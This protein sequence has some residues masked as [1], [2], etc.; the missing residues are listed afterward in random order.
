MTSDI[1][2]AN[3]IPCPYCRLPMRPILSGWPDLGSECD[4]C[5]TL[6]Y[7]AAGD[8]LRGEDSVKRPTTESNAAGQRPSRRPDRRLVPRGGRRD[9]DIPGR[10]PP[11][12][13]ADQ[14]EAARA[15]SVGYLNWFGF[16]VTEAASQDQAAAVI[17][18]VRPHAVLADVDL[19]AGL[20]PAVRSSVP[21][22]VTAAQAVVPPSL[23]PMALLSKPVEL[24]VMLEELRRV[25]RARVGSGFG[26]R[27]Q[28]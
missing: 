25:L 2:P 21:L 24:P 1:D 20:S 26:P 4:V 3:P 28:P 22:I 14:D 5:G 13:V 19:A 7:T 11:V 18:S 16:E 9:S 6:S 15:P 12:L 17:E 8:D 23:S 27:Q 10:Y